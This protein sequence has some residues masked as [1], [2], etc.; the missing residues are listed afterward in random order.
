M[1]KFA[2]KYN[3]FKEEA[4]NYKLLKFIEDKT[5]INTIYSFIVSLII[6]IFALAMMLNNIIVSR[7][8]GVTYP[9]LMSF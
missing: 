6:I 7:V 1:E 9:A 2:E 8:V 3:T 4:Q 5:W